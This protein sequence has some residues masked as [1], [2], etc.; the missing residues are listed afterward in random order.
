LETL[1]QRRKAKAHQRPRPLRAHGRLR[2]PRAARSRST[3]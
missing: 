2:L 3:G 1:A